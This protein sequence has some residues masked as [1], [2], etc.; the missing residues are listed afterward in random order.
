LVSQGDRPIPSAAGRR[1]LARRSA[2]PR[3]AA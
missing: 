3:T 1:A 2:T